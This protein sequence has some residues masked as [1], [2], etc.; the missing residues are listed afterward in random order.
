MISIPSVILCSQL[1]VD[2]GLA[3]TIIRR[4]TVNNLI[5][6]EYVKWT[7]GQLGKTNPNKPNFRV[8]KPITKARSAL[9]GE[10]IVG[11]IGIPRGSAGG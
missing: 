9:F 8:K 7:L 6:K 1:L 2:W 11:R 5:T 10:H 3:S 4:I